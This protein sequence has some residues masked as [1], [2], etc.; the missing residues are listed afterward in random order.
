MTPCTQ[1]WDSHIA[2][3]RM[4]NVDLY[5][6]GFTLYDDQGII[7]HGTQPVEG[8]AAQETSNVQ[9]NVAGAAP[10]PGDGDDGD[11]SGSNDDYGRRSN[12]GSHRGPP[13][14]RNTGGNGRDGR[15]PPQPP[16]G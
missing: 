5:N 14:P 16:N 7:F 9:M 8:T 1:D 6:S 11:D 10:N 15:G 12:N 13:P 3:Q 4:R 2:F